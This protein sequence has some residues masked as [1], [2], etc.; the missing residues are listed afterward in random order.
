[1]NRYS[2]NLVRIIGCA[3]GVMA[4]A[5]SLA[6]QSTTVKKTLH[7]KQMEFYKHDGM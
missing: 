3:C 7:E 2:R 6:G 4:Y 5:S 1:M